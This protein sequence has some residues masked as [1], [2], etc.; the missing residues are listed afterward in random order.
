MHAVIADVKLNLKT[1]LL[2]L[3]EINYSEQRYKHYTHKK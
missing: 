3:K 2:I 1:C